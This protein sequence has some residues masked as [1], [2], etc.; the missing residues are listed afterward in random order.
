LDFFFWELFRPIRA[1]N[2]EFRWPGV[3]ARQGSQPYLSEISRFFPVERFPGHSMLPPQFSR[4][5]SLHAFFP[6]APFFCHTLPSW[7][8]A[9]AVALCCSTRRSTSECRRGTGS[10][11]PRRRSRCGLRCCCSVAVVEAPQVAVRV[12]LLRFVVPVPPP[13]VP[14]GVGRRRAARPPSQGCRGAVR[15]GCCPARGRASFIDL[16]LPLL[17]ALSRRSS[18]CFISIKVQFR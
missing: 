15:C 18:G 4:R 9:V 3:P 5:H 2:G 16:S 6:C 11:R 13:R 8:S 10:A 7:V 1:E 17:L 14:G 12:D